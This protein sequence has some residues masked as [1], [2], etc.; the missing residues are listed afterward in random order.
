MNVVTVM[1]L[2]GLLAALAV[3]AYAGYAA[4]RR[5]DRLRLPAMMRQRG[6]DFPFPMSDREARD[7]AQAA[8]RCAQCASKALCDQWLQEPATKAAVLFCPNAAYVDR[9]R[10]DVR[11]P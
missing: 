2:A 3:L 8:R 7:A 9:L 4:T 11:I 1:L 10:S 6:S 5:D